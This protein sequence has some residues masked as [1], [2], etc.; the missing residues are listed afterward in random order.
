MQRT[1]IDG[2]D[3]TLRPSMTTGNKIIT[4][5]IADAIYLPTE[6][7]QTGN[8]GIPFVYTR[9][10]T[11]QVVIPGESND[12]NIIILKGLEPGTMVFRAQPEDPEKF[13]IRGEELIAELKEL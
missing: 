5:A 4:N 9:N 8:D 13:D 10:G 6:C 11:K 1:V 3:N 12:K 7:L 2:T